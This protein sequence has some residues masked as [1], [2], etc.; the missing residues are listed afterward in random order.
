MIK[1]AEL[2][3]RGVDPAARLVV[4][5]GEEAFLRE[6]AVG[7]VMEAL[8]EGVELRTIDGA[9]AELRDLLD[10]LR[11]QGLFGGEQLIHLK[12]ADGFVKEH[13]KTL[14]RFLDEG[15]AVQRLL[16]EGKA[17]M[18]K[19]RKTL[20]KR[21]FLAAVGKLDGLV[22]QC[23]P[24]FD[25]PF[26][27]QGPAWQS[28]LSRW[29]VERAGDLGKRLSMED[30]YVLHRMVGNKLRELD[31]ELKKLATF[32]KER[33]RITSE[34]IEG[35]VGE[36]RLAPVFDLAE[37]VAGKQASTAI[38]QS[39]LLFERG[40][41]DFSGRHV[42]DAQSIAMMILGATGSRLRKVAR[43]REMMA[44]GESFTDAASAVRQPPFFRDR[45][46]AQVEAWREP[47]ALDKTFRGLLEMER[48]L[49]TSAG[50]PRVLMDRFLVAS[51]GG[52]RRAK[53]QAGS[54]GGVRPWQR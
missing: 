12:N 20:P 16:I 2:L 23:D 4:V 21:G 24:L 31:G 29:V 27:G 3:N 37:A 43:V 41:T 45:L 51:L 26:K 28:P 1:V 35:C 34:D 50:A 5:T 54:R 38:E 6:Q 48:G 7:K 42:R 10:D 8:P 44:E 39:Q 19:G 22:V 30:A 11:M 47:G 53:V 40:V 15:E 32:V 33:P 25:S 13:E 14:V 9:D 46:R 49:K 52:A 36:G 18:G 17:L